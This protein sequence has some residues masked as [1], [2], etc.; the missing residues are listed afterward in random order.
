VIEL[1]NNAIC[2]HM[3]IDLPGGR[4]AL[5][6]ESCVVSEMQWTY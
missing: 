4:E 1:E 2:L 3:F 5:Q 6:E